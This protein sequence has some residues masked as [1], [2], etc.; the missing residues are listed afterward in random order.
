MTGTPE[1]RLAARLDA[2]PARRLTLVIAAPVAA[3][4][5]A[6]GLDRALTDLLNE[7]LTL[8]RPSLLVLENYHVIDEPAIHDA[9]GWVLDYLPPPCRLLV[10]STSEPPIPTLARLRV[11]R[12]LTEL[13]LHK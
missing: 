7:L 11:R 12:Q 10:I 8:T 9:M 5:P 2:A 13:R 1:T 6:A 3:I 4:D